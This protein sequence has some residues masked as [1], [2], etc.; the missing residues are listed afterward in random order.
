MQIRK[1]ALL[2]M[3]V[4]TYR[5]LDVWKNSMTLVEDIYKMS[6]GFP[7]EEMYGLTS[8]IRRCAVSIPSNIAEGFMRRSTKEFMQFIYIALGSL[9]EL[10]TQVEIAVRLQYLEPAKDTLHNIEIIRKQLFALNRSL[11]T[12]L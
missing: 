1:S 3:T 6:S 7:K 9:G 4:Q 10:D 12:K 2:H 5:E 11:K 8:Q